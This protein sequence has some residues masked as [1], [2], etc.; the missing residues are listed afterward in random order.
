MKLTY[1]LYRWQISF[2]KG[3]Y[4]LDIG[5]IEVRYL[6][7]PVHEEGHKFVTFFLATH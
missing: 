7:V 6:G 3:F 5:R 4:I 2:N 1:C